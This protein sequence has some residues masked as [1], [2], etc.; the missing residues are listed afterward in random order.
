LSDRPP[1]RPEGTPDN[2]QASGGDAAEPRPRAAVAKT[3]VRRRSRLA[4]RH[5]RERVRLSTPLG[6]PSARRGAADRL[7]FGKECCLA[8]ATRMPQAVGG[9]ARKVATSQGREAR[10]NR[11]ATRPPRHR[12]NLVPISAKSHRS[13]AHG[14]KCLSTPPLRCGRKRCSRLLRRTG[15][16]QKAA[17]GAVGKGWRTQCVC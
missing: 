16:H 5:P 7:S 8:C 4:V 3:K 1:G 15:L 9:R 12:T 11:S 6:L 14:C 17:I 13:S 10:D 2:G